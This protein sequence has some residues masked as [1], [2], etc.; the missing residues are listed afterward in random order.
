M[1]EPEAARGGRDATVLAA[2]S[3]GSGVLAYVFFA[4]VTRALGAEVSAPV[5]VLWAW[6]S[7]AGAALTFPLQ[8][9]IARQAA[10][11]QGEAGV[12]HQLPRV[13]VAVAGASLLAGLVAWLARERLFGVEGWAFPLLVVAVGLGSAVIGVVRGTLSARHRFTAVGIGLVAENGLRCVLAG[14]LAVAGVDAPEAYGAVLVAG[15]AAAALWPSAL[16]PRRTG[17]TAGTAA[18]GFVTGASAGQLLAQAALTGGPVLLAA[19]GGAPAEVTALFAGLALFRAPYTLA[20][21]LVSALTGRLT[22][23]VVSGR[24]A[25][26]VRVRRT[27]VALT[28]ALVLLA[29]LGGAW[30]GPPVM[31][32]VF[33]EGVRLAA[34]DTAVVAVG[35]VFALANLVLL[36]GALARGRPHAAAVVW[37]LAA[38]AGVAGYLLRGGDALDRTCW[39]F[40]AVEAAAWVGFLVLDTRSDRLLPGQEDR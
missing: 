4:A 8:H 40:L 15:Y 10:I 19:V 13:L 17:R 21:G 1:D 6:W 25:A 11:D 33:G 23:L 20:I 29:G 7:F 38:P 3:L 24:R 28:A 2:G 30:L 32:L 39:A 26:L 36:V 18:L 12:R 37:L 14:G 5:A 31:E 27:V 16:V 34:S 35:S 22:R 9:W